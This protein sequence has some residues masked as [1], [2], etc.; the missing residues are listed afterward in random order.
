MPPHFRERRDE[1]AQRDATFAALYSRPRSRMA[2]AEE[3][4]AAMDEAGVQMAVVMGVGWTDKRVATEANDY[5]IQSVKRFPGRL[6][7]FCSVNPIWGKDSIGEVERCA[8]EGAKGIG[9][10]HPDS[11]GFDVGSQLDMAPIMEAARGLGLIVLAHSSEPV[12]HLYPGKGTTTP[13]KLY[14]FVRNFPENKIVCAHWG[15]GLPFY[16]LMPEV[17]EALSNVYYDTAASPLLYTGEIFPTIVGLN[18]SHRTLF[19]TDF[20]LMKHARLIK[21]IEDAHITGEAR[22]DILG[23]NAQALLGL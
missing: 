14:A 8:Q 21:Q 6:V 16:T 1:Y 2:T 18:Q 13:E 11:Q 9:E 17:S 7:G 19:G 3:L 12:G 10:L 5:I 23:R 20:P 22:N 4:V 15:G